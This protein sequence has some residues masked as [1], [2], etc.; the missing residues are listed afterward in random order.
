MPSL[1]SRNS[2]DCLLVAVIVLLC[3]YIKASSN[4]VKQAKYMFE[5]PAVVHDVQTKVVQGPE[6]IVEKIVKTAAGEEVTERTI[7]RD[8]STTEIASESSSTPV[9]AKTDDGRYLLG[10]SWRLSIAEQ[11]NGTVWAGY[12]PLQRLYLLG[13]LGY[14]HEQINAHVMVLTRW[15]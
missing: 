3:G 1:P 10:G 9:P 2:I 4:A 6:R 5:H 14:D 13:G 15:G 11:K 12:A 7:T 8:A